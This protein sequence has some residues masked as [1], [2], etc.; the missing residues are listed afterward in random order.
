MV[1]DLIFLLIDSGILLYIGVAGTL[2][3]LILIDD[4][5]KNKKQKEDKK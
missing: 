4:L 1:D 5:I 2:A 3:G